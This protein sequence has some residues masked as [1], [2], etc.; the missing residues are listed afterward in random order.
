MLKYSLTELIQHPIHCNNNESIELFILN[1]RLRS[2]KSINSRVTLI[3]F[4]L[5]LTSEKTILQ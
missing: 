5:M 4:S 3:Q 2:C 1:F